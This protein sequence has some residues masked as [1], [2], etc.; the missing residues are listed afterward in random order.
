MFI[1]VGGGDHKESLSRKS[2]DYEVIATG[3][4]FAEKISC[5]L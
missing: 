2:F 5:L 1:E 3:L 4:L